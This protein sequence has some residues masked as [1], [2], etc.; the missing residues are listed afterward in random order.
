MRAQTISRSE[1]KLLDSFIKRVAY[2]AD[3]L[4]PSRYQDVEDYIQIGYIAL[5]KAQ[6]K[7]EEAK[8]NVKFESF[9]MLLIARDIRKEAI[10]STCVASASYKTKVMAAKIRSDL[11]KGIREDK[12]ANQLGIDKRQWE[13]MRGLFSFC[14]DQRVLEKIEDKNE[15]TY[16]ALGDILSIDSL[17][18]EEREIIV[19]RF[20]DQDLDIPRTSLWRKMKAIRDKLAKNGY[21]CET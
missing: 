8:S 21:E 6:E 15:S 2:Q 16:C 19:A 14:P 9:A 17:T 20:N 10:R 13:L 18:D 3:R 5:W 1:Q 4:Y 12:I 11:S 7:W